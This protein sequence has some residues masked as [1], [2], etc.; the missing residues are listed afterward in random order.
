LQ[1]SNTS[2]AVSAPN[3]AILDFHDKATWN[4]LD[5]DS[6]YPE[7]CWLCR[8]CRMIQKKVRL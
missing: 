7:G 8:S 5:S 1:L 4:S 6:Y 2:A 3:A